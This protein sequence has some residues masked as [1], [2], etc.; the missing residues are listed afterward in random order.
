M[1]V[2]E[3]VVY[4]GLTINT[5][6]QSM[7][8]KIFHPLFSIN[9]SSVRV[10][11]L[12]NHHGYSNIIIAVLKVHSDWWCLWD[13][14]NASNEKSNNLQPFNDIISDWC[15]SHLLGKMDGL[16]SISV[17]HPAQFLI[18]QLYVCITCQSAN[19]RLNWCCDSIF[20]CVCVRAY[21]FW[22]T[23]ELKVTRK[24][25]PKL[26]LSSFEIQMEMPQFSPPE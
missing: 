2:K 18:S 5:Y 24:K 23:R 8:T 9:T 12:I 16:S 10:T 17:T 25:A 3:C 4:L 14:L 19:T 7:H 1:C 15:L 26:W 13:H 6:T 22:F 11:Q 20:A 21:T